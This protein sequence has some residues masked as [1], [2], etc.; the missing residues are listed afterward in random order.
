MQLQNLPESASKRRAKLAVGG[1]IVLVTLF[2]LMGW[3]MSRPGST[4]Y[5]LTTSEVAAKAGAGRE[6][7]RINGKVMPGTI[8]IQGLRSSFVISDGKT[9]LT[10]VTTQPLPYAFKVGAEAVALGTYDGQT[11]HASEVIAKCPSKFKP[12]NGS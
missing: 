6:S 3:A 1:L 7:Y 10:V 4:A 5:Y 11:L 8:D 9:P 12:R 2:A